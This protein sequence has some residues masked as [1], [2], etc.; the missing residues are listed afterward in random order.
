[1]ERRES[2]IGGVRP[3]GAF[4]LVPLAFAACVGARSGAPPAIVAE[5][6]P[7]AVPPNDVAR[8][9][10]GACAS[11]VAET[12]PYA[13][14]ADA[15]T[16]TTP[17]ADRTVTLP[18]GAEGAWSGRHG[19]AAEPLH[20]VWGSGS[21]IYAAGT[22]R[23]LH[24]RDRGK[25]FADSRAPITASFVWGTSPDDVYLGGGRSLA[26]SADGGAT[27]S[28]SEPFPEDAH[29][30][31]LAAEEADLYVVGGRSSGVPVLM[32]SS[33]RGRTW[34]EPA[35]G[36]ERG[37][38]Y[39]VAVRSSSATTHLHDVFVSGHDRG[40]EGPLLLRSSDCGAT[41]SSLLTPG[42]AT[43]G[44]KPGPLCVTQSGRVVLAMAY[45]VFTSDDSGTSWTKSVEVGTE[46][47]ALTCR[48]EEIFAG[49]RNRAFVHSRDGGATWNDRELAG[50][51]TAPA[52]SSIEGVFVIENGDAY[53]VGEGL[54][55]SPSGSIF[56]RAGRTR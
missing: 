23:L 55:T 14:P 35:T 45:A 41:W 5:I 46:I 27:W 50:Q 36:I 52:L 54:Y 8:L 39:G 18:L 11:E 56:R 17:S 10:R 51:W 33:D 15:R 37:W 6:A 38:F 21:E 13:A 47:L 44:D 30:V 20:A 40:G 25:T 4:V 12:A 1:M 22:S 31:A 53:A 3:A 26:H 24:S 29:V 2:N 48:G 9:P 32:H 49:G 42:R 19:G 16:L 28:V 7:V 34:T 43:E